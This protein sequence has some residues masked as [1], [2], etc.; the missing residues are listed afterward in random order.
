MDANTIAVNILDGIG[1]K[2]NVESLTYCATRLRFV[3]KDYDKVDDAIVRQDEEVKDT[4][5]TRGQY[6]I[7][8]GPEVVKLV[9][10]VLVAL[11]ASD[12]PYAS[13]NKTMALSLLEGIGGQENLVSLAYCATRLRLELNDF[14]KIDDAKVGRIDGVKGTFITAGQ[15][16]IVLGNELVK[17]VYEQ[18]ALLVKQPVSGEKRDYSRLKQVAKTLLGKG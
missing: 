16:Q 12:S 1:G 4:F 7:I 18:M 14:D 13:K 2:E 3:L 5:H 11:Q 17:G 6:Q 10:D 9:Y 8:I 15:Y